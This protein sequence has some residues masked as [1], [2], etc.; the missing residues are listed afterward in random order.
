MLILPAGIYRKL[1]FLTSFDKLDSNS[2]NV[3]LK[4]FSN[5]FLCYY[6]GGVLA[7]LNPNYQ[8]WYDRCVAIWL[9]IEKCFSSYSLDKTFQLE[10][11]VCFSLYKDDPSCFENTLGPDS[12]K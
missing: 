5:V 3:A 8:Y 10:C 11:R 12:K 6:V 1:M 4:S 7:D 2:E 9:F